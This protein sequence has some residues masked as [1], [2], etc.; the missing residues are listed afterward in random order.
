MICDALVQKQDSEASNL[1]WIFPMT[2]GKFYYSTSGS[3]GDCKPPTLQ[4]LLSLQGAQDISIAAGIGNIFF[5]E[6]HRQ[7]TWLQGKFLQ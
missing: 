6:M 4:K 3:G 1:Q 5:D 2:W 7:A